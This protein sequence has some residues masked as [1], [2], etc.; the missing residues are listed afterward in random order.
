MNYQ[1]ELIAEKKEKEGLLNRVSSLEEQVKSLSDE[2]II[3]QKC[4]VQLINVGRK[5]C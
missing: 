5:L 2:L 1:Q 4:V 3:V